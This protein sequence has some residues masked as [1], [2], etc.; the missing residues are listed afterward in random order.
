MLACVDRADVVIGSRYLRGGGLTGWS[1]WRRAITHTAHWM[2]THVLG[3]PYD[4]TGGFRL[5]DTTVFERVDLDVIRSDGYAFLVELLFTITRQGF[6]VHELP[7]VITFREHG[8]SKISR[9]EIF[10][11]INTLA[12]L[13][14]RRMR[15]KAP[16]ALRESERDLVYEPPN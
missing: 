12:R 8:T 2:T 1:F 10:R 5:Y 13:G 16:E 6:S 9:V 14:L 11:A 15:G 3:I 4:C 7:I